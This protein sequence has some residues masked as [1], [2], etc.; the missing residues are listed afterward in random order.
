MQSGMMIFDLLESFIT[1]KNIG[2]GLKMCLAGAER[3]YTSSTYMM[4]FTLWCLLMITIPTSSSA[5]SNKCS[6]VSIDKWVKFWSKKA[7]KYHLS[8]P[9]KE[10]KMVRPKYTHN[11]LGD[12]A[13][14]KRWSTTE[15]ALFDKLCIEGNLKEA[16]LAAYLACWLCT[17]VLSDEDVNSIVQALLR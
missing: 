10:K 4:L 13:T 2:S 14:H 7:I 5:D 6:S 8:P 3:S 11:P 9:R 12:I 16:Y 15:N 1:P 17:F